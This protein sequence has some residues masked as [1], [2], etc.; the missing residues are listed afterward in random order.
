MVWF[1]YAIE[2]AACL[3]AMGMLAYLVW[4]LFTEEW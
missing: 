3:L 2:A 1:K 4:D